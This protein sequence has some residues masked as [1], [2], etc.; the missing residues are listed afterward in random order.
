[1]TREPSSGAVRHYENNSS[2]QLTARAIEGET[3]DALGSKR[4]GHRQRKPLWVIQPTVQEEKLQTIRVGTLQLGEKACEKL[5]T[6]VPKDL[7]A[8]LTKLGLAGVFS[9]PPPAAKL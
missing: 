4:P 9:Q 3:P 6:E 2:P 5:M 8:Q 7:N 1:L